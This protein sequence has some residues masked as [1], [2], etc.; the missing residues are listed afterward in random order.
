MSE[1]HVLEV[2]VSGN[3]GLEVV[4]MVIG[5]DDTL[6]VVEMIVR[7][8]H[9]LQ[10]LEMVG[11]TDE[12]VRGANLDTTSWEVLDSQVLEVVVGRDDGLE[13]LER[14][15]LVAQATLSWGEV[16]LVNVGF[17]VQVDEVIVS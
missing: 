9:R 14:I 1:V 3:D 5:G 10:V 16:S 17:G 12:T 2:V 6:Q 7:R 13:V 8:D 4:Q 15:I 11:G